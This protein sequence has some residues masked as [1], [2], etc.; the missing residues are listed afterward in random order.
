MDAD[1][2]ATLAEGRRRL[3]QFEDRTSHQL[4][5]FDGEVSRKEQKLGHKY[6]KHLE[7]LKPVSMPLWGVILED[8]EGNRIYKDHVP[9]ESLGPSR[10][11][12]YYANTLN[13]NDPDTSSDLPASSSRQPSIYRSL[14][15]NYTATEYEDY[16]TPVS[17]EHYNSFEPSIQSKA[18]MEGRKWGINK[19]L[20]D[21]DYVSNPPYGVLLM[22]PTKREGYFDPDERVEKGTMAKV[23]P[24]TKYVSPYWRRKWKIPRDW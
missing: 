11:S 15:N 20:H 4:D 1:L 7:D 24:N 19:Y 8:S 5:L 13:M 17:S 2:E 9:F 14:L 23:Q 10:R 21:E 12:H 3:K 16:Q 18:I 22:R 6:H